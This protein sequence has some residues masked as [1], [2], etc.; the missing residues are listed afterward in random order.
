M[1]LLEL[2]EVTKRV[3]GEPRNPDLRHRAGELMLRNGHEWEGV[4]WVRSA[5]AVDP[6]H[7]PSRKTLDEYYA[8]VREANAR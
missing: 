7:A 8:R 1:A 4:R 5:L 2:K 6:N 3:A